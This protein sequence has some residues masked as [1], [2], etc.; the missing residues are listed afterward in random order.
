M[1]KIRQDYSLRGRG[2]RTGIYMGDSHQLIET[3]VQL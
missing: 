3:D 2:V 1:G